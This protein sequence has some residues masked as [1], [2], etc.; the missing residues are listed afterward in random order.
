MPAARWDKLNAS[1]VPA[2]ASTAAAT[3]FRIVIF[4]GFGWFYFRLAI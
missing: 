1:K 4:D 2:T 3:Q